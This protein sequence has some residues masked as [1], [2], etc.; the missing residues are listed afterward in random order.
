MD[1][2]QSTQSNQVYPGQCTTQKQV[3]SPIVS[4]RPRAA[5]S[6]VASSLNETHSIPCGLKGPIELLN[7]DQKKPLYSNSSMV[8]PETSAFKDY[9]SSYQDEL[10]HLKS[11]QEI[12]TANEDLNCHSYAV[13]L[14]CGYGGPGEQLHTNMEKDE[15][16]RAISAWF[17]LICPR[18]NGH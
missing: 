4:S 13:Q 16:D 14:I 9:V 18:F 11:F 17:D 7:S 12:G 15:A 6:C 10:P 8:I 5:L 1:T 2:I 3:V